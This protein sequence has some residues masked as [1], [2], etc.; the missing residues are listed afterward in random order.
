ML[1]IRRPLGRLIFNMGIAIPGKTVFLIETAPWFSKTFS[2]PVILTGMPIY[3]FV[4]FL[5][6]F[7]FRKHHGGLASD[8]HIFKILLAWIRFGV[9]SSKHIIFLL[10]CLVELPWRSLAALIVL[11]GDVSTRNRAEVT[12]SWWRHQMEI[13]SALLAFCAWNSPVTGDGGQWRGA[14][15]FSL[16]CPWTNSWTNI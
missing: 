2:G 15:M 6:I 1:K 3:I 14:L 10:L 16:I 12:V 11:M 7:A 13:F 8:D 4:N 9:C 5:M